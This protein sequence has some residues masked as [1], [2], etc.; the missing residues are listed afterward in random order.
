MPGLN[1]STSVVTTEPYAVPGRSVQKTGDVPLA[2]CLSDSSLQVTATLFGCW[3]LLVGGAGPFP[4]T[5][6]VLDSNDSRM[7]QVVLPNAN[8]CAALPTSPL[9]PVASPPPPRT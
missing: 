7:Q 8:L 6:K 2:Q 4:N 5:E 3:R 1:L 9:L